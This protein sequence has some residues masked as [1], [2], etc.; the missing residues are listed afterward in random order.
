MK[1]TRKLSLASRRLQVSRPLI[2]C[3]VFFITTAWWTCFVS[4]A[5]LAWKSAST[6]SLLDYSPSA[7]EI[8]N[9]DGIKAYS[10]TTDSTNAIDGKNTTQ[11]AHHHR[12]MN[13]PS[14][15][16]QIDARLNQSA[17]LAS[18]VYPLHAMSG[19]YHVY[20]YI[21]TPPQRQTLIVDT[22]SRLTAFP[23]HPH[24]PDCGPHSTKPFHLN[25]SST[26]KIVSCNECRLLQTEFPVEDHFA[27]NEIG[28]S[29]SRDGGP[30]PRLRANKHDLTKRQQQLAEKL[31]TRSIVKRK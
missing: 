23:C 31:G 5:S 20:M 16:S 18:L 22:G 10:V 25:Q 26:Y 6:T 28:D 17:P 9:Q 11:D 3:G 4:V 13:M 2:M 27:G 30:T 29:S 14:R 12:R 19:T 1:I 7:A 24:C 21:G 15:T 8:N